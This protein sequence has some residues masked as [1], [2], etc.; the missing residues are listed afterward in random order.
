MIHVTLRLSSPRQSAHAIVAASQGMAMP[1]E[2]IHHAGSWHRAGFR[3][4][5]RALRSRAVG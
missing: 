1:K 3:R 2:G 4:G 5:F